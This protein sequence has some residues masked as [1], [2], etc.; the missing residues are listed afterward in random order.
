MKRIIQPID[1]LESWHSSK[2]PWQYHGNKDDILRR[3]ILFSELPNKN[4]QNVL[5]IGCGQ[6]F[7]TK[8]IKAENVIGVDISESA[9]KFAN[10]D[11]PENVTFKQGSIFEIDQLFDI[12]FDLIIIT[13]VLY[14][15]YIG[16]SSN[17]IYILIDK[18]LKENGNLVS[19]HI[20]EW[21]ICK[22][23][24][25]KIKEVIYPYREYN[26]KLEIFTK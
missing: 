13:G 3:E 24:Y 23:P 18:I 2:D 8:K 12:K 6:G 22:F 10:E 7:I 4:Y 25:L 5:D 15:Q 17:L 9:I 20:N 26:H 1:N 11:C 19:V 16:E 14:K 21:S